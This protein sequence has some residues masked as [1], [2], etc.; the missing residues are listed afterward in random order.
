MSLRFPIII[1]L[2]VQDQ[3]FPSPFFF[4]ILV[5]SLT[6]FFIPY[7]SLLYTLSPLVILI[8]SHN[9]RYPWYIMTLKIMR[10]AQTFL[11]NSSFMCLNYSSSTPGCTI[12]HIKLNAFQ[13]ELLLIPFRPTASTAFHISVHDSYSSQNV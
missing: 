7:P 12:R 10:L 8:L 11:L 9:F 13:T 1:M 4:S 3:S 6:F 2:S 5:L